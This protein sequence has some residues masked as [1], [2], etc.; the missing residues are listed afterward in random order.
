MELHKGGLA[1]K[2]EFKEEQKVRLEKV[3]GIRAKELQILVRQRSFS[4]CPP[5]TGSGNVGLTLPALQDAYSKITFQQ[6]LC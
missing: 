6:S 1:C 4:G 5:L 2:L 3:T